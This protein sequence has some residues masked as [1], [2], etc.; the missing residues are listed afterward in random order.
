MDGSDINK[1][2]MK[3]VA[4]YTY[5]IMHYRTVINMIL[6]TRSILVPCMACNWVNT[7]TVDVGHCKK[8]Q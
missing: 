5:K 7:E 4:S 3:N 2:L 6:L 8:Y 1:K